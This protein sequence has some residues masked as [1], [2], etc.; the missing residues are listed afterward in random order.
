MHF[1]TSSEL[2][3][4][5]VKTKENASYFYREAAR[6]ASDD[7]SRELL[8]ELA[9]EELEH[10][11]L[12][13]GLDPEKGLLKL[14]K[15]LLDRKLSDSFVEVLF[16]PGM[17]FVEILMFAIKQGEYACRLYLDLANSASGTVAT[18][19]A[20]FAE[21]ERQRRICLE[22]YFHLKVDSDL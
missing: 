13:A 1:D 11:D 8:E 22:E 12:F 20:N 3:S 17:S 14:P 5:A 10:R 6:H 21:A 2:I 15:V 16:Y 9:R 7:K 19:L 4:Y 18:M